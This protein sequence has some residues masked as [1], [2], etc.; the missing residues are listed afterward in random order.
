MVFLNR[1]NINNILILFLDQFESTVEAVIK[2]YCWEKN[3]YPLIRRGVRLFE[4]QTYD[5][6]LR[7]VIR[8]KRTCPLTRGVC[9]L[10]C[11]LIGNFT[12]F[13]SFPFSH[14]QAGNKCSFSNLSLSFPKHFCL[15][16]I[17]RIMSEMEL[18]KSCTI[19]HI[20]RENHLLPTRS[21]TQF[22]YIY[23]IRKMCLLL[24]IHSEMR[25]QKS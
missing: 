20:R 15:S 9:F 25:S 4:S 8:G 23:K 13:V 2:G 22:H 21:H 7:M 17:W 5:F 12:A 24:L 3:S 16:G 18:E 1:R 10:E 11:P 14:A 6:D 19:L